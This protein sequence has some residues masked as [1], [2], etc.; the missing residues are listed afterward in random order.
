MDDSR[1]F[2]LDQPILPGLPIASHNSE[3]LPGADADVTIIDPEVQWTIDPA[4]FKSKSRN[5]P[6]AGRQVQGR[7]TTVIVAGQQRYRQGE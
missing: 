5:T 6:F 3:T 1:A 2:L 4:A 7:A